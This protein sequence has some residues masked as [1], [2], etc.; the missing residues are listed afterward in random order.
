MD[1]RTIVLLGAGASADAGLPLT[2]E[3]AAQIVE[4]ANAE[5]DDRDYSPRPPDWVRALNSVYAGMVGHQGLRGDNP[6]R[7]VNVETLISAVRLLQN[8]DRHEVAPFVAAWSPALD[9]FASGEIPDRLGD[10]IAEAV[11]RRLMDR[12]GMA[13]H[14]IS[15]AVASIARAAL[16]PDLR[17]PFTDAETFILRSLV[18]LLGRLGDVSYLQPLIDLARKQSGGLDVITLNYDLSIETIAASND[19]QVTRG[20]DSWT[21]GQPLTFP[22]EDGV[23]NLM[24]LH[25]SLDWRRA[26]DDGNLPSELTPPRLEVV[27]PQVIVGGDQRSQLSW[28]VVGDREK[29]ATD[30]PTLALNFAARDA[31]TRA[32]HLAVVGYSFGDAHINAMIRDWLAGDPARTISVLARRWPRERYYNEATDF[33][34]AL[35]ASYA[36]DHD[37]DDAPLQAQ[38]IPVEGSTRDRLAEVLAARPGLRPDPLVTARA[39]RSEDRVQIDLTWHGPELSDANVTA[40][41]LT[42]NAASSWQGARTVRLYGPPTGDADGGDFFNSVD[43]DVVAA[44]SSMTVY[45]DAQ[46]VL[47]LELTVAGAS[48]TGS[49]SASVVVG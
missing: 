29:L 38:M 14:D 15:S 41:T 49:Q 8:R 22:S 7:A 33:R 21:P 13:G 25:G 18:D 19:L 48:I 36:R 5:V 32:S 26:A 27:D 11:S 16:R 28:I 9:S 2:S 34:S 3:L 35:L 20:I 12:G 42:P 39:T 47:P 40:R 10:T 17:G 37:W 44:E 4:M 31:L 6:L 45:A 43:L 23:L 46:V 1:G 24:K 30:G